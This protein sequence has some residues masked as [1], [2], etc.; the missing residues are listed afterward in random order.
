[1][2]GLCS[3][4]KFVQKLQGGAKGGFDDVPVGYLN[5]WGGLGVNDMGLVWQGTGMEAVGSGCGIG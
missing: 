4:R 1:M 5:F 3:G 2:G